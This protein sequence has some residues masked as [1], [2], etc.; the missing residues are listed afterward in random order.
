[1]T[2]FSVNK[3]LLQMIADYM[4][5]GFLENI[6][7]MFKYDNTLYCFVGDLIKDERIRVRIG[8]TALIEELKAIRPDEVAL[9]IPSLLPLLEDNNPTVRGDAAYLIGIIGESES[10]ERLRPLLNDP[11]P[12]VAEV[13][14]EIL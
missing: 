8:T 2:S 4:N 10:L 12:Q 9:A 7:D 6:I 1:M 3:Q 5:K 13:V 11:S 14:R